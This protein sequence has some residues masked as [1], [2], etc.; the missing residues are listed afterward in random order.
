METKK[1]AAKKSTEEIL[2]AEKK[3]HVYLPSAKYGLVWEGFIN[4]YRITLGTDQDLKVPES[5]AALIGNNDD[6]RKKAQETFAKYTKGGVKLR[7][8]EG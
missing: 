5:V 1:V 2:A 8:F 3:V 6:L 7:E 4:G